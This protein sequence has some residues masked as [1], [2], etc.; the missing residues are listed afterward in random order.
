MATGT[1]SFEGDCRTLASAASRFFGVRLSIASAERSV[2]LDRLSGEER[3]FLSSLG[4]PDRKSR[5][6]RGRAALKDLLS[7]LGESEDTHGLSFP[8]PRYS[9][10]H[11]RTTAL[12]A[13]SLSGSLVG[14][15]IDLEYHRPV[16]AAAGPFFLGSD[17]RDW[18]SDRSPAEQ[19]RELLRLWTVK[20]ALFKAD[21]TNGAARLRDYPLADASQWGGSCSRAAAFELRY[22]CFE[23]PEGFVSLATSTKRIHRH[24]EDPDAH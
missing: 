6:R 3:D 17:E 7:E 11:S 9:L 15:G 13:G 4:A 23:L 21:P 24:L 22:L 14:L 2:E 19:S 8:H 10:T 12:A 16:P 1:G 20:E 18:L 5:W